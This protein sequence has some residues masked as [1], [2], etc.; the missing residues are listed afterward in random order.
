MKKMKRGCDRAYSNENDAYQSMG[1]ICTHLIHAV[2]G[3]F[4]LFVDSNKSDFNANLS[5]IFR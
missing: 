3:A 1:K 4:Q 2:K 5:V